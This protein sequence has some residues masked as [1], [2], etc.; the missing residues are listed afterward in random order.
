LLATNVAAR[1]LDV[2][3]IGLVINYELPETTDLLTHRVGRTGRMGREGDAVTLLAPSD[4]DK[5]RKLSRELMVRIPRKRW[6]GETP[7]TPTAVNAIPLY[8][9]RPP[10]AVA[11]SAAPA[12][13]LA[14]PLPPR[15]EAQM[16]PRRPRREAQMSPRRPLSPSAQDRERA[17]VR[18]SQPGMSQP[19]RRQTIP[20][21]ERKTGRTWAQDR[22]RLHDIE[23]QRV[24]T[25]N[26]ERPHLTSPAATGEGQGRGRR[27]RHRRAGAAA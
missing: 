10:R 17:W 22:D 15:R 5:W 19:P 12:P 4:A 8:E 6:T 26:A 1:G 23:E 7:P 9:P 3:H 25:P 16:S 2:E 13:R 18:E 21:S 11:R 14:S 24:A 20:E 27:P